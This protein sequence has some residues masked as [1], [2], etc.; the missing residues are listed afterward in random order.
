MWARVLFEVC[1]LIPTH[2]VHTA[3]LRSFH[4]LVLTSISRCLKS[5][6]RRVCPMCR[7][8]FQPA[9]VTKIHVDQRTRSSST[10]NSPTISSPSP[11]DPSIKLARELH[12]RIN[13]FVQTGASTSVAH[14]LTEDCKSFFQ[15]NSSADVRR[16]SPSSTRQRGTPML[17]TTHKASRFLRHIPTPQPLPSG[18]LSGLLP[19]S[20]NGRQV[21]IQVPGRSSSVP[22]ILGNQVSETDE[23]DR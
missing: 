3:R 17:T 2:T 10:T 21:V 1:R 14:T 5:L 7:N 12:D 6:T 13:S 11:S 20:C 15:E 23:G 4:L 16:Y 9:E 19:G 8:P 18:L 22:Q